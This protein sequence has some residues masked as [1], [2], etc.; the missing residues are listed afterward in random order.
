MMGFL[1]VSLL[2]NSLHQLF[3]LLH[4]RV[5]FFF[6]IVLAET[7]TYRNLVGVVID[8]PDH[9]AALVG[10]GSTGAATAGADIIDVEIEEDHFGFLGFRET[11]TQYRI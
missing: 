9:M 1:G 11:Y 5:Y 2:N 7:E 6:R 8:G 4:H 10:T 3:Q